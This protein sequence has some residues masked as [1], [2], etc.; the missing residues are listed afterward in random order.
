MRWASKGLGLQKNRQ[1]FSWVQKLH[2]GQMQACAFYAT[3]R[4]EWSK[5]IMP[6]QA[7]YF[8]GKDLCISANVDVHAG[9]KHDEVEYADQHKLLIAA[10]GSPQVEHI[11]QKQLTCKHE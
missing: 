6:S 2:Q 4:Q 11:N 10:H 3:G 1:L 7:G 5:D 9:R 8:C